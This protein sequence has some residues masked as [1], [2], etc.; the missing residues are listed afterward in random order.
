[1]H[2][3]RFGKT[4]IRYSQDVIFTERLWDLFA[5]KQLIFIV[6]D[7]IWLANS[8][9]CYSLSF[10]SCSAHI[11]LFLFLPLCILDINSCSWFNID[12]MPS[13]C[14]STCAS[15]PTKYLKNCLST[16]PQK[17]HINIT[18]PKPTFPTAFLC[19]SVL[20]YR[21]RHKPTSATLL[22]SVSNSDKI[23]DY[24]L[25]IKTNRIIEWVDV[26]RR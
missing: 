15:Q 21:K 13:A 18:A 20:K 24:A 17:M 25:Q 4:K 23:D 10:R 5:K 7:W 26:K 8:N 9:I 22:H 16:T 14:F 2:A 3:N 11:F 1:M 6:C 19:P 12:E